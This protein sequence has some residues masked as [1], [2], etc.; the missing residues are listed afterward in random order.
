MDLFSDLVELGKTLL[1]VT[2]DQGIANR[3]DRVIEIVDGEIQ[4]S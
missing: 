3:A 2:H 4:G 1:V